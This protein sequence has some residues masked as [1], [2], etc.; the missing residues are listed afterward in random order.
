MDTAK[1]VIVADPEMQIDINPVENKASPQI[2]SF[3]SFQV[4]PAHER[5]LFTGG[6]AAL[7]HDIPAA[8]EARIPRQGHTA[9]RHR[10]K[11]HQRTPFLSI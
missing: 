6:H 5:Y 4:F 11:T 3:P 7:D 2:L 8:Q 1:L 9:E 10:T